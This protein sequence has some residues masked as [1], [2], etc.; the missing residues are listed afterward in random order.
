[1]SD[2][3]TSSYLHRRAEESA[4]PTPAFPVPVLATRRLPRTWWLNVLLFFLTLLSTTLFGSALSDA[5]EHGRPLDERVLA[6]A[7]SWLLHLDPKLLAGL[8]YSL[9]LLS[10]LLAH[11]MGHYMKCRKWGVE[12]TLPY[13]GPSPTLLGTVG[14]FIW[15]RSPIYNR[16]SL[17]DI[18][19]YGPLCG[20]ALV[21]P[22]LVAG[23]WQSR[24]CPGMSERALFSFGTPLLLM[25][26]ERLR[27]P[28]IPVSDICLHP[29][30]IAAW[31]GLLATAI[32]LLP[33]GQ[34]DGGHILYGLLG[35]R[36]HTVVSR[37]VIASLLAAAF[38]YWPWGLWAVALFF[39]RRHPAIYDDQPLDF[40]R[41]LI[42]A[43]AAVLL[44]VSF[45][46]IPIRVN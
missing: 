3:I 1:M 46:A 26:A 20:F 27:F 44:L 6:R 25:V 5:F 15:I 8:T 22:F 29:T 2:R 9:P 18:G 4:E 11:E 14:A 36:W 43:A 16:R 30:A 7:Y 41:R 34:L 13:F 23:V 21:I 38:F 12:A 17:F 40:G 19:V 37:I 39:L 33:V 28:G 31:A 42:G 24:I 45:A 10:I 35:R 32:N